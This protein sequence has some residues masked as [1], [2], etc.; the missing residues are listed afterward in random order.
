MQ[1]P[2]LPPA[3]SPIYTVSLQSLLET[4]AMALPLLASHPRFLYCKT[5]RRNKTCCYTS[6]YWWFGDCSRHV[7]ILDSALKWRRR[8]RALDTL[9]RCLLT[10]SLWCSLSWSFQLFPLRSKRKN[11][12]YLK[13]SVAFISSSVLYLALTVSCLC[14]IL[15][16][17]TCLSPAWMANN[18]RTRS[19]FYSQYGHV[20]AV[21]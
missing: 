15:V 2:Y 4:K 21:M 10:R 8:C 7:C 12:C 17:V 9:P 14:G 6:K 19:M 11:K 13:K 18:L 5:N 1:F 3:P 16:L 20:G